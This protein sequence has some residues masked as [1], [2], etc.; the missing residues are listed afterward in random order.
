MTVRRLQPLTLF[1]LQSIKMTEYL[2]APAS[3]N[4]VRVRLINTTTEFVVKAEYFAHP[5][6]PGHE[7]FNL[8]DA[9]FL[10]ENERLGKKAVYD[11]GCR[12]DF[13]NYPPETRARM[14]KILTGLKVEK[15]VSEILV[16]GGVKLESIG[17]CLPLFPLL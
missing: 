7:E 12:R 3:Q 4:T 10:I 5:V 15:N 6:L 9:S 13:W 1:P 11:L 8:T 2:S 16:E 14:T 17:N